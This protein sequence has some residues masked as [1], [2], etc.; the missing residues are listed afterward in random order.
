MEK[1][2]EKAL[3]SSQHI[4][5]AEK[6][7]GSQDLSQEDLGIQSVEEL[8][9]NIFKNM[10]ISLQR[11]TIYIEHQDQQLLFSVNDMTL[12]NDE[13]DHSNVIRKLATLQDM[14]LSI[15]QPQELRGHILKMASKNLIHIGY[16]QSGNATS[17]EL[18]LDF[19]NGS[20]Q[21]FLT[22]QQLQVIKQIVDGFVNPPPH[23]GVPE[24]KFSRLQV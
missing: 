7:E 13:E 8:F 9:E 20:L 11:I 24:V 15:I 4:A 16:A 5:E 17:L 2:I 19:L 10:N 18:F 1:C 3:E 21:T 23:E 12:T 22:P 6:G 14:S